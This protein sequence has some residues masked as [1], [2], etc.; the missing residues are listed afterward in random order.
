MKKNH[1][2][3]QDKYLKVTSELRKKPKEEIL[4]KIK[5]WKNKN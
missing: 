5:K 3:L 4:F 2:I 1:K